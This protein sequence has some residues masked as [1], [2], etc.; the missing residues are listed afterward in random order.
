MAN[1][2][3]ADDHHVF[4]CRRG[5]LTVGVEGAASQQTSAGKGLWQTFRHAG[6][7]LCIA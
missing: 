4:D 5:L 1:N 7:M 2:K 3:K 6:A